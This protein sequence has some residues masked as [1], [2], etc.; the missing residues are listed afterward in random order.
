AFGAIVYELLTGRRAF[1]GDTSADTMTAILTSDPPDLSSVPGGIPPAMN[2]VMRRCLEK[3]ARDRFQSARDLAFALEAVAMDSRSGSAVVPT[4]RNRMGPIAAAAAIGAVIVGLALIAAL[5]KGRSTGPNEQATKLAVSISSPLGTTVEPSP[6]ISADGRLVAF[7]G[8]A[9][10]A[11]S[12]IFVRS[13]DSFDIRPLAGTEGA[14]GPFWSPDG[15]SLGFFARSKM[16]R[17]EL[18]G[19]VPRAIAAV[20]DPRGG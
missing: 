2:A 11:S 3:D 20:S 7:V 8:V 18:A 1:R 19:G 16:W 9:D 12:R 14:E 17:V 5:W 6:A 15:R 4:A 10:V 13:L